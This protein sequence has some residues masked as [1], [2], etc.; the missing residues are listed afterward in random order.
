[1]DP[2]TITSSVLRITGSCFG[3]AKTLWEIRTKWKLAPVTVSTL[4]TQLK[5][6]AA[7]LSQIRWLLLKHEDVLGDRPDLRNTFDTTLTN[8]LVVTTWLDK[9]MQKITKGVLDGNTTE[10]K[11]RFRT[12]WK[13]HEAQDLSKQLD[14]QQGALIVLVGLLQMDKISDIWRVVRRHEALL[15]RIAANTQHLRQTRAVDAPASIL[16]KTEENDSILNHLV[17]T[18]EDDTSFEAVILGTRVYSNAF[19]GTLD[20]TDD[21]QSDDTRTITVKLALQ[22]PQIKSSIERLGIIRM[23][24]K[25][26]YDF[27]ATSVGELSFKCSQTI[28]DMEMI[29]RTRYKGLL[30]SDS[31]DIADV[32]GHFYRARV[33]F[34]FDLHQPLT[35]CA[36][37]VF[38]DPPN[39]GFLTLSKGAVLDITVSRND[40][41]SFART[42]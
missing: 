7:S 38:H 22:Y 8:C 3:A 2:L 28:E 11:T 33:R 31:Q 5:L 36:T 10:W 14:T 19:T 20:V 32:R 27:T 34:S 21:D 6:T 41:K 30:R 25:A 4:S 1:M 35:S 29:E 26:G 40:S 37:G 23:Y 24:A 9:V 16:S 13:E 17:D 39:D 42:F 18:K 12:L 15:D